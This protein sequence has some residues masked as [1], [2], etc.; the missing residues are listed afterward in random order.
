[1][2]ARG[3][4]HGR[5]NRAAMKT[6]HDGP[7]KMKQHPQKR[8]HGDY[9]YYLGST[10]QASDFETTTAYLINHIQKTFTYGKDA[11]K[12]LENL[13][14]YDMTKHLPTVQISTS[15]DPQQREALRPTS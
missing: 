13:K 12:A 5:S 3:L 15:Q 2:S 9:Q 8:T 7:K 11:A 14:P 10:K 6:G 4:G 1:M